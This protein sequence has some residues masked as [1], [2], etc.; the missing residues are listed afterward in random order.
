MWDSAVLITERK[1]VYKQE[2]RMEETRLQETKQYSQEK[3]ETI[4]LFGVILE[5]FMTF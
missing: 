3:F 2:G 1:S 4:S 5:L